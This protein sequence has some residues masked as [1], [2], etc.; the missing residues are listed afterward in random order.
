MARCDRKRL[1]NGVC[2][3]VEGTEAHEGEQLD[4][5]AIPALHLLR[6]PFPSQD[7]HLPF[8]LPSLLAFLVAPT[9]RSPWACS[10]SLLPFG[11]ASIP[12]SR[13]ICSR[14]GWKLYPQCQIR[15]SLL[16]SSSD[17]QPH[18]P[19]IFL[20]FCGVSL[21]WFF[22]WLWP[23]LLV[24]FHYLF[25]SVH[26]IHIGTPRIAPFIFPLWSFT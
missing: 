13:W 12:T 18:F 1:G 23:S 25:L 4:G 16:V 2:A 20:G 22:F 9:G 8:L 7:E 11:S 24:L 19:C 17:T 10:H 26:P 14:G 5:E 3:H 6:G 15:A 21:P